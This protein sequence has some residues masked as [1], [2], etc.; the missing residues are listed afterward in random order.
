MEC[1]GCKAILDADSYYCD[2]CGVELFRCGECGKL[3]TGKRCRFDGKPLV[4]L[5]A[6]TLTPS[7][8]AALAAAP[9]V[10]TVARLRLVNVEKGID[11]RPAD[12]DILG[13]TEGPH[14]PLLGSHEHVSSRHARVSMGGDGRWRIEDLGSTNGTY[15]DGRRIA[16]RDPRPLGTTTGV[17]L[18]SLQLKVML[19]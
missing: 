2:Q 19:E 11:L 12:G 3:G 8:S 13:R 14:A 18:G 15:L 4:A 7:P 5:S 17:A 16:A 1:G 6:M 9:S 10:A